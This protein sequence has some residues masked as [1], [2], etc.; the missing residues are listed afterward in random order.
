MTVA[1]MLTIDS[2]QIV[3][4]RVAKVLTIDSVQK[5]TMRVARQFQHLALTIHVGVRQ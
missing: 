4:M 1:E 5:V 2:V 3:A